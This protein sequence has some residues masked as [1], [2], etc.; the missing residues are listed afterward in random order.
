MN[1]IN[2]N[3]LKSKRYHLTIAEKRKVL[4]IC[5]EQYDK[6]GKTSLRSLVD[7]VKIQSGIV[8]S[9]VTIKNILEKRD[10]IGNSVVL[11]HQVRAKENVETQFEL[12][13]CDRI[14][15]LYETV[16]VIY[17]IGREAAIEIQNQPEFVNTC[18]AGFVFGP[19]WWQQFCFRHGFRYGRI[20]GTKKAIPVGLITEERASIKRDTKGY[21]DIDVCNRDESAVYYN[22]LGMFIEF[23]SFSYNS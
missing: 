9:Y 12:L 21:A 6:P 11:Q 3:K 5:D 2:K 17:D 14:L 7:A 16:N 22:S 23:F 13:L 8:V 20:R 19:D 10:E 18:M 4:T 15:K 1:K